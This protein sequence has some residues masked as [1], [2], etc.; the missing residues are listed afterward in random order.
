MHRA[1]PIALFCALLLTI[2]GC[3]NKSETTPADTGGKPAP[4]TTG[5]QSPS[6]GHRLKIAMIPKKR[7]AYFNACERGGKDAAKDL[8]DVDFTFDA[9]TEDKS[10]EQSRLVNRFAIGHYDAITVA[11]NDPLQIVPAMKRA[12]SAGSHVLTYDSDAD[13]SSGREFFVNQASVDDIA[14]ALVD[15]MAQ[16]VG[17]SADVAVVSST[18]TATNQNAWLKSM[19]DYMKQ[20]YPQLKQVSIEYGGELLEASMQKAQQI[21]QAYPNVKGIWGITSVAFPGVAQ[22]VDRA[23]KRG[24][25]AVVGL[26]TPKEMAPY[27]DSGTVKTVILWSAVD[28]GY[29]TVYAAHAAATGALKP[30]A[31]SLD[32]G[33]LG[34]K[35]IVGDQIL[36]GPPMRFTKENIHQYDF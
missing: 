16:Q 26:S 35:H 12:R 2:A 28:L 6:A 10:E 7:L 15:E 3:D 17:A 25:V 13:P 32:A 14:K 20:R 22:A 19:A 29:L 30:G 1:L 8:G 27:V 5:A 33:R 36:L 23:G 31:T 21:L 9:P 18:P 11:C 24:Q 4:A 34:K